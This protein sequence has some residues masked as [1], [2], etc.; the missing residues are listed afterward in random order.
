M[1][2]KTH[3]FLG[4]IGILI[5]MVCFVMFLKEMVTLI[6]MTFVCG[7]AMHFFMTDEQRQAFVK[8]NS[9]DE[10]DSNGRDY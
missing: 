2:I 3:D 5:F 9:N 7:V 4:S 6:L 10:S 8:N 1:Q